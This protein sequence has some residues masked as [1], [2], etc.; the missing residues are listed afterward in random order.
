MNNRINEI[1]VL[2]GTAVILMLLF[3]TFVDLYDFF[4][5]G[6]NYHTGIIYF[7]GR[8]AAFTFIFVSGVSAVLGKNNLKNAACVFLAGLLVT[9]VTYFFDANTFV[10]FGVLQFL[11]SCMLIYHFLKKCPSYLFLIFSAAAFFVGMLINGHTAPFYWLLPFGIYPDTF[12]T[13]D[14][15]PIFPYISL[16]FLGNFFGKTV[17]KKRIPLIRNFDIIPL[18]F[19][20]RH[21]LVIYLIHQPIIYGILYFILQIIKMT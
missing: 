19:L 3:H 21:S 10:I 17:Y 15:Y 20:G 4:G 5:T 13:V 18:S 2:R 7:V 11:S 14:Y 6:I 12:K 1:D 8:T 16:F 9:L